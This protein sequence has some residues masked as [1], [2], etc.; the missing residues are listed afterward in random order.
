MSDLE[1]TPYPKSGSKDKLKD[2]LLLIKTTSKN[3]I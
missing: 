3:K 1:L 2:D